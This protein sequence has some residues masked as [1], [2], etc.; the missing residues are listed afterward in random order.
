VGQRL[1]RIGLSATS[2]PLEETARFLAGTG[3]ACTVAHVAE[4]APLE[5]V[6]EPLEPTGGFVQ[7]LTRRLEPELRS[8]RTTLIFPNLRS[9]AER[10]NWSLRRSFP[11]LAERIAVHHSSLAAG[12]R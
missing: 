2:A 6:V 10:L 4:S 11:D 1:Q 3:S 8:N 5:L 12:R 7:R 9:L